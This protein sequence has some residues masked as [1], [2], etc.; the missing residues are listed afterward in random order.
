MSRVDEEKKRREAKSE[1]NVLE[2]TNE[3]RQEHFLGTS[4]SFSGKSEAS[5][6][7]GPLIQNNYQAAAVAGR[8]FL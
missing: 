7:G 8:D 3:G 1:T 6:Q 2:T 4:V 5:E